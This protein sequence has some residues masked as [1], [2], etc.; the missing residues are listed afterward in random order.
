MAGLR[1]LRKRLR[2]IRTTEQVT[3]AMRTAASAK[4]A[5]V[6]ASRA[7]Y[8]PY[9]E[10]CMDILAQ[11][12]AAGIERK[13]ETV[14]P[15]DCIVLLSSNRGLCGG[16]NT[17]IFRFFHEERTRHGEA[18]LLIAGGRKAS[19]ELRSAGLPFEE[20]TLSDVPTADEAMVLA[21]R[22]LELY[23]SGEVERILFVYQKFHNMLTQTPTVEQLLPAGEKA[24]T[25]GADVLYL[26]DRESIRARLAVSCFDSRV[27]EILLDNAA[28]A[29][30]ATLMAMR[31]ASDNARDAGARL[32]LTINRRRQAEVTASVIETA[33]GNHSQQ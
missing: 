22:L 30:A 15:R 24:K 25:D 4:Y 32:E 10:A 20:V 1:E 2:S 29:Q 13:T 9:S 19:A 14:E 16:Y 11:L 26:P 7:A 12:G 5:K 17:E 31:N 6:G 33:S 23:V 18:P 3:N 27:Y 28:G 21:E 8:A